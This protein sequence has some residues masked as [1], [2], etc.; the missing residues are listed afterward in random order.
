[1]FGRKSKIHKKVKKQEKKPKKVTHEGVTY[2]R[3]T[4]G[5]YRNDGGDILALA[6]L[7]NILSDRNDVNAPDTRAD[8][9][10]GGGEF[11]GA[12]ASGSFDS[13]SSSSSDNSSSSD[14]SGGDSGGGGGGGE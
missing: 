2:R 4:R 1:M 14:S 10:P 3:D 11:S 7:S 8:F 5:D 12:G 6:I 9:T 13:D